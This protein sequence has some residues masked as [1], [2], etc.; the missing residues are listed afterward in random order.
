[1]RTGTAMILTVMMV[2][3]VPAADTGAQPASSTQT[4]IL[5]DRG[6]ADPLVRAAVLRAVEMLPVVPARIKVID[7]SELTAEARERLRDTDAFT[8]AGND[9]IYVVGETELLRRARTG[10][11]TF[12]A[13]LAIVLWH[14]MQ[15]LAG[16]NE[17]A[18][19]RA[20]ERLWMQFVTEGVV[21]YVTGIRYHKGL[22]KRPCHAEVV[23]ASPGTCNSST[24]GRSHHH[25]LPCQ[26]RAPA[27]NKR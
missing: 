1:M 8:V 15:H 3:L 11:R 9:W 24:P 26:S 13:V 6:A 27:A 23:G 22:M 25:P 7:P 4:E 18:A 16:R 14:E 5:T 10:T 21:D 2:G 12:V 17:Q 19:C 20:E